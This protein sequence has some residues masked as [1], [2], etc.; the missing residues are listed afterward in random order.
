MHTAQRERESPGPMIVLV[1]SSGGHLL[2]LN[3]LRPWWERHRRLWVTFDAADGRTLLRGE[4]IVWAHHPT[5]RNVKNLIRNLFLAWRVL[6]SVRPALVVSTGAGV[7]VPFFIAG[8]LLR[9]RT[10]F[11]EAVERIETRSLSGRLCYPLSD[12]FVLQ[13]E[14]QR[15]LYPRGYVIGPLY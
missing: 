13:W 11:I 3:Q 6:R 1:S 10:V 9:I 7:A 5:T 2:L 8:K 14:A 4:D 12:V 15:R